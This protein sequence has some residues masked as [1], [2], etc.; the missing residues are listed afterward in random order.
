MELVR[1]N[2]YISESGLCSRRQADKLI[3]AGKVLDENKKVIEIGT[4]VERGSI[5]Y[6]DGQK[7]EKRPDYVYIL[8]NKPR[9][10]TCTTE[11]TVKGNIVDFVNHSERI[12]PVGR[13]DKDSEG[14]I[15]L[16]NDGDIVNRILRNKNNHEKEYVVQVDR[17]IS[18][19]FIKSLAAGVKIEDGLTNKCIVQKVDN[20]RF[21]IV[22]T[23]GM[24]RQ[25]R[26]M[27][28]AFDYDVVKLERVRIMH[29]TDEGLTRKS[30]RD[31]T[32][33]ELD[34]IKKLTSNSANNA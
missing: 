24:N 18:N 17:P 5:V 9:G 13:L 11:P 7:I 1:L 21:R 19:N 30:W 27:C 4:K 20:Y 10:I 8:L 2:K 33:D 15:I 31:L 28:E 34:E 25:I 3:E 23:Q 14:L 22:L 12:F 26:K 16:T 32:I 6:V 29:I